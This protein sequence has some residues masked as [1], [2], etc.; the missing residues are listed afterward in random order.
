MSEKLPTPV[1]G[2]WDGN[3]WYRSEWYE[4]EETAKYFAKAFSAIFCRALRVV[5][6]YPATDEEQGG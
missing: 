2:L 4:S 3:K 1:F 6:L 5:A